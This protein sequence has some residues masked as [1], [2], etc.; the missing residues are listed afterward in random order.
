MN[1]GILIILAIAVIILIFGGI[2]FHDLKQI[3]KEAFVGSTEKPS[4]W[5]SGKSNLSNEE[6]AKI[7]AEEN[8]TEKEK[9]IIEEVNA[10]GGTGGGG[11][12]GASGGTG[13][14]GASGGGET[15][16]LISDI[17]ICQNA[18]NDNLCNGLDLTYGRGYRTACCTEHSLCC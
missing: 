5:I 9:P 15:T 10:T 3:I 13:G 1:K 12:S 8:K 2:F 4:G 11:G 16:P 14:S 7:L 17:T 18:Q 6:V